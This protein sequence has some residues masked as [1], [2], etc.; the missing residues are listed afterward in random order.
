MKI[1]YKTIVGSKLYNLD[2]SQSDTDIKG[3]GMPSVDNIIG[4][5]RQETDANKNI[6]ENSDESIFSVGKFL[7]VL[8]KGN[9]TIFEISFADDKFVLECSTEGKEIIKFCREN[10]ITKHLFPP[11]SA[12]F[13]AQHAD[14]LKQKT[15]VSNRLELLNK[16]GFD[17]KA[18]SHTARIGYQCIQIMKYGQFNP[19]LQGEEREVCMDIKLGKWN[20][21][22][23]SDLLKEIDKEMY[24]AYKYSSLPAKPDYDKVNQFCVKIYKDYIDKEYP[25]FMWANIF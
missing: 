10:F 7:S 21:S 19:T 2:T 11:Y 1:F 9:P 14:V 24:D 13:R 17:V 22:R 8:Y 18:A 15:K 4:L 5:K 6:A 3:F 16:Y 25:K 20:L 12:Y 23:T